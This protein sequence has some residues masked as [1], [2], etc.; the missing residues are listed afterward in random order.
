MLNETPIKD[1]WRHLAT[2]MGLKHDFQGP[3]GD[4]YIESADMYVR[5]SDFRNILT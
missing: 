5:V 3:T 2:S 4:I 1:I